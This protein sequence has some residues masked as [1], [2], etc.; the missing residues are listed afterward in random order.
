MIL[1]RNFIDVK[2]LATTVS[3]YYIRSKWILDYIKSIVKPLEFTNSLWISN[4]SDMREYVLYS[5]QKESLKTLVDDEVDY[6]EQRSYITEN[7]EEQLS[8]YCYANWLGNDKYEW[9]IEV[10]PNPT[11]LFGYINWLG[12]DNY[13]WVMETNP[14]PLK[15]YGYAVFQVLEALQDVDSEYIKD[16]FDE[17]I[18]TSENDI[19]IN[20][21]K[22]FLES[23]SGADIIFYIHNS[24]FSLMTDQDKQRLLSK[25]SRYVVAPYTY[26]LRQF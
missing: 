6:I 8:L 21:Y 4:A 17:Y 5:S 1:K 24:I 23:R 7:T 10:D 16:W 3:N 12:N 26:E 9:K 14:N 20:Q 18:Y 2:R 19:T 11:E 15:L 13:E 22:W 25:L